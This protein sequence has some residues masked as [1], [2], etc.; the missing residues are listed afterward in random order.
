ML[1]IKNKIILC[2]TICFVFIFSSCGKS[3]KNNYVNDKDVYNFVKQAF[4]TKNGY[5]KEISEHMSE[6]IFNNINIY[7]MYNDPK[8]KKPFKVD[9]SLKQSSQEE[10]E[11]LIYINMIY[12]VRIRDAQNKD[13]GGSWNVPVK[14]IVKQVNN[15]W[16]IFEK[17]E[18]A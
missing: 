1:N 9:F 2:I 10:K 5:T 6:Q 15:T 14:Y 3:A 12:S 17:E 8:Y 18:E 11:N 4:L 7:K 13:I 16:Y